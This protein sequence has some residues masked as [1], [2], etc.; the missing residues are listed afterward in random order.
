MLERRWK[1]SGKAWS[2]WPASTCSLSQNALF[3]C[4][5]LPDV[6]L[7]KYIQFIIIIIVVV[8]SAKEV[9]FLPLCVCLWTV[10]LKSVVNEF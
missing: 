3:H 5:G 4:A 9:M 1:W 2:H 7:T 10:Q 8:T 6:I